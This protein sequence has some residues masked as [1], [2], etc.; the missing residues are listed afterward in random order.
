MAWELSF[1][2]RCLPK[3]WGFMER[4]PR[5]SAL[6]FM[7]KTLLYSL[8]FELIDSKYEFAAKLIIDDYSDSKCRPA[9]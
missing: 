2:R 3:L 1:L 9:K 5:M 6:T 4:T 8:V 7:L